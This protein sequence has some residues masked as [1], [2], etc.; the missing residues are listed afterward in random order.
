MEL[1]KNYTIAGVSLIA[2]II[3]ILM[4][5][6]GVL[7]SLPR[8]LCVILLGTFPLII[9]TL[10]VIALS[11][12]MTSRSKNT[13]DKIISSTVII[14]LL[15]IIAGI[16]VPVI[17]FESFVH[18]Q[19]Q[20]N[21]KYIVSVTGLEDKNGNYLNDVI[22][23][24]PMQNGEYLLPLE[25]ID[26]RYFGEWHTVIVGFPDSDKKMLA[27]Q[28]A[29]VNLTNINAE[30]NQYLPDGLTV[31][32]GKQVYLSPVLDGQNKL[33]MNLEDMDYSY[34]TMVALPDNLKNE[35]DSTAEKINFNIILWVSTGKTGFM[36]RAVDYRFSINES[37]SMYSSG[38]TQVNVTVHAS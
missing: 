22:V 25:E 28:H 26:N 10:L 1:N 34:K 29:G 11:A 24:L 4:M 7:F 32:N 27:F 37:L 5:F 23:P 33:T 38:F 15:V 18:N 9:L 12:L 2:V 13:S 31:D 35:S 30:F 3:L 19:G 14:G 6:S 20:G 16:I 17:F 8:Q 36:T 21:I